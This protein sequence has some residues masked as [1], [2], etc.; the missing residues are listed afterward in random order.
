MSID[1]ETALVCLSIARSGTCVGISLIT[2]D[3][4]DAPQF[5]LASLEALS[6]D[7]SWMR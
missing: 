2:A 6:C 1:V 3:R 4:F 5:W 7:R